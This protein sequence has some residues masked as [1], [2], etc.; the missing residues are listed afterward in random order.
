MASVGNPNDGETVN[1]PSQD[2]IPAAIPAIPAIPASVP[3]NRPTAPSLRMGSTEDAD[4]VPMSRRWRAILRGE[5]PLAFAERLGRRIFYLV[6]SERRCKFC[7]APFRG[8]LLGRLGYTPSRKN[9]SLCERCIE[10]APEGGA[11]VPVS[12]LFA[13]VRGYTTIAERLTSVE[14]T[15]LLHRFY[16]TASVALLAHDAILGQ[17]AGDEVMAIFVPGLA[18][19]RYPHRAVDSAA[20]FLRGIGYG[21][22]E[23]PWLEVGVGICTGEEYVGNVGGGGFKDFTAIGDITNTAARLQASAAGGEI[24]MCGTT[25]AAMA[26]AYGTIDPRDLQL[27]GKNAAVRSFRIRVQ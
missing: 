27:K 8:G 7:N 5:S 9:P 22:D 15:A 26:G 20:A 10:R 14:T 3:N 2:V 25:Y 21:S 4:L 23:G 12:V 18:G 1:Q 11:L 6:P 16:Q 24:V 19:S 17:I 13:D